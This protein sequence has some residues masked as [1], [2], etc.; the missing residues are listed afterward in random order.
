[1]SCSLANKTETDVD[2]IMIKKKKTGI[3]QLIAAGMELRATAWM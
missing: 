2:Q 3:D 1:M